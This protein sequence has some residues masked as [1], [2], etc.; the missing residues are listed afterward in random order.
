MQSEPATPWPLALLAT[1]L[2]YTVVGW[3][4]LLLAIPPGYA[5]PLFPPAGIALAS[6]MVFG[7]RMMA[8]VA[9]GSFAV[10][11]T[12]SA[13]HGPVELTSLGL[14]I[15]FAAGAAL[16]AG[17]GAWLVKRFLPQ[18]IQLTEPREIAAFFG[19]GGAVACMV[20]ATAATGALALT[21]AVPN[22]ELAFAWWTWWGG[23]TLGVLIAAPIALT[24]IGRPRNIWAGRRLAVALP[25]A[26]ASV[27]ASLAII[28]VQ[29]QE[30]QRTVAVFERDAAIARS[31]VA[32]QLQTPLHALEAL[33]SLYAA[34]SEVSGAEFRE[35]SRAWIEGPY[36]P[37][38]IGWSER[39]RRDELDAFE[40]QARGRDA[41]SYTV[42]DISADGARAAPQGDEV[43][44]VRYVEPMSRNA[45]ALGANSL[46]I[47]AAQAAVL[48]ARRTDRPVVSASFGLSP[49]HP[50]QTGVVVFR[51][52]YTGHPVDER[53]RLSD[54]RG[55]VFVALR[56]DDLLSQMQT[57]LPSYLRLCVIDRDPSSRPRAASPVR[58]AASRRAPAC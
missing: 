7:W 33:R 19:L 1:A 38:A 14:P 44:A 15:M 39:V 23:D 42:Y 29:R 48:A 37:Y 30:E 25:L 57:Q 56:L 41:A 31:A 53:Q 34:S 51:A 26:L 21:G 11:F 52:V 35:A 17:A 13:E 47:A 54:T 8:G 16:Q 18:P 5:S 45:G 24:L 20:S 4:A 6:V 55:V 10:N 40:A 22:G 12:V 50:E 32:T 46:S 43:I 3:V 2:A 36:S 28:Q 9:L 27:L 49:D 58:P